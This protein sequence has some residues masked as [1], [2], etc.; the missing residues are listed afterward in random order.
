L[1]SV[2]YSDESTFHDSGKVN[3]HNFRIWGSEHPR[4]S[5]E[6][7]RDGPKVKVFGDLGKGKV[8]GP[9]F[10][11]ETTNSETKMTKKNAFTSSKTAHSLIALEKC[12]STTTPVTQ[13]GE[14]VERRR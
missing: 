7:F 14:L 5:L 4:V 6:H 2:I 13:G 11:M 3:S 8:Y 1:D 10:L 12:A 9:F